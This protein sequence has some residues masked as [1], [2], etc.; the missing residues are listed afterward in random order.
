MLIAAL[1]P[2]FAMLLL[3][4]LVFIWLVVVRA[5]GGLRRDMR[6]YKTFEP[7]LVAKNLPRLEV[8]AMRNLTNLGEVPP[9]FHV[10]CL[11]ALFLPEV[12]TS[13]VFAICSWTFVASRYVHSYVHCTSNSLRWRPL[14]FV[15]SSLFLLALMIYMAAALFMP[16]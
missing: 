14:S 11:V 1:A 12:A 10:L 4:V 5:N 2:L 6:V 16:S 15:I 3:K 13:E 8:Q 7:D 9:V